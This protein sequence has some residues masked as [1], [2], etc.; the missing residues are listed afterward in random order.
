MPTS[1]PASLASLTREYSQRLGVLTSEQLQAA[2]DRFDL[3]TLVGAQPAS[4]GL[5]G[6]NVL[7]ST[8]RG[9]YVLRGCPHTDPQ[10][11]DI[12][13]FPREQYFAQRLHEATS[14][15]V[16]WPYLLEEDH[17]IF[18]W[19]FAIMPRLPGVDCADRE[20]WSG[21]SAAARQSIARAM[22]RALA[23][24]QA[25]RF[26][27]PGQYDLEA[28][29]VV[30]FPLSHASRVVTR[31]EQQL[32]ACAEASAASPPADIAWARE[33]LDGWRA[34][35]DVPFEP[36]FVHHDYSRNNV[37]VQRSGRGWRVSGVF[38]LMEAYAGDGEED[39]VRTAAELAGLH[40]GLLAREFVRAYT[41]LRPPRPGF[42]D[43]FRVHMLHDRLVLW[44]YGQRNGV[45]FTPEQRLRRDW[46]E[47]FLSPDLFGGE[48]FEG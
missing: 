1:T 32:E 31:I 3:G 17:S 23:R 37:V 30:P 9:R 15:A 16:P 13:Q 42:A 24:L 40:P 28:R 47:R 34:A 19:A 33:Q 35:L 12:A 27:H 26:P 48:T 21:L 14:V 39:L 11:R 36:V 22:G 38:D 4:Q 5:F 20:V 29:E 25:L 7:L 10:G 43:R 45:W 8:T 6:Q 41:A 18:G 44:G 2:L 46:L